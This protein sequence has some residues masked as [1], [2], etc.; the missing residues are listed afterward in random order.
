MNGANAADILPFFV[1]M[2]RKTTLFDDKRLPSKLM[3]HLQNGLNNKGH[4]YME[5]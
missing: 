1:C 3:N 5:L 2:R 4:G